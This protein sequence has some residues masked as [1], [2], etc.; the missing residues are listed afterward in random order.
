MLLTHLKS[1]T[2]LH[3]G[4]YHT[5]LTNIN[6]FPRLPDNESKPLYLLTTRH[7]P[8]FR[9]AGGA[10][11]CCCNRCTCESKDTVCP[12]RWCVQCVPWAPQSQ[13]W[14]ARADWRQMD[15]SLQTICTRRVLRSA[16]RRDQY[17]R[18]KDK[19]TFTSMLHTIF[20]ALQGGLSPH[21]SSSPYSTG[22]RVLNYTNVLPL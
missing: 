15:S 11:S 7:H 10:A 6:L 21:C 16:A 14:R 1:F 9:W 20:S 4:S 13:A 19:N 12:S 8:G 22:N 2:Y 5:S 3:H 17:K 18:G